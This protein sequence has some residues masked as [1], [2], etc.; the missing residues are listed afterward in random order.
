MAA[1]PNY[2]RQAGAVRFTTRIQFH[3]GATLMWSTSVSQATRAL[4]ASYAG[5]IL[6]QKLAILHLQHRLGGGTSR[7][8][9]ANAAKSLAPKWSSARDIFPRA[10]FPFP[11]RA[12]PGCTIPDGSDV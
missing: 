9:F 11:P 5:A 6:A 1:S 2:Q 7:D 12:R 3:K 8:Y 10:R 4:L